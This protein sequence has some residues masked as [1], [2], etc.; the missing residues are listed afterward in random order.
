MSGISSLAIFGFPHHRHITL[1][2]QDRSQPFPEQSMI[3]SQKNPYLPH[4]S[5]PL[6]RD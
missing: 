3:V 6:S 5:F 2:V 1:P 4:L